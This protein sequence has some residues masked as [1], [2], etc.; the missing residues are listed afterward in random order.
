MSSLG[1][2][3]PQR[4]HVGSHRESKSRC[5]FASDLDPRTDTMNRELT[6]RQC[7][8]RVR[9]PAY[10]SKGRKPMI[11]IRLLVAPTIR[12]KSI[13]RSN[14]IFPKLL[15]PFNVCTLLILSC[16]HYIRLD[17]KCEFCILNMKIRRAQTHLNHV[18]DRSFLFCRNKRSILTHLLVKTCRCGFFEDIDNVIY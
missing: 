12:E 6:R 15:K 10:Q 1:P 8:Y 3:P 9:R 5:M 17:I 13:C 14:V 2:S 7:I 11:S 4:H 16:R 18:P